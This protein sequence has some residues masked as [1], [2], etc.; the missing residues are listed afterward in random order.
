MAEGI[1]D[2]IYLSE[3]LSADATGVSEID[4][5]C[6][7]GDEDD[8]YDIPDDEEDEEQDFQDFYD[9]NEIELEGTELWLIG[10]RIFAGFKTIESFEN[11]GWDAAQRNIEVECQRFTLWAHGLGLHRVGHT[12]LDYQVR[13]AVVVKRRLA[14]VLAELADDIQEL[15]SIMRG[16]RVAYEDDRDKD[17]SSVASVRFND[18]ESVKPDNSEYS[19]IG[20]DSSGSFHEA[21]FRQKSVTEGIDTLY[22]LALIIRNPQNRPQRPLHRLYKHIAREVREQYIHEQEIKEIAVVSNIQRHHLQRPITVQNS[23]FEEITPG[24]IPE[25][26]LTPEMI[27]SYASDS[28]YLVRRIGIANARRKQQ[29]IYWRKHAAKIWG[30]RT[31]VERHSRDVKGKQPLREHSAPIASQMSEHIRSV[32]ARPDKSLAAAATRLDVTLLRPHDVKSVASSLSLASTMVTQQG[33]KLDWPS[34][35]TD[36]LDRN[37]KTFT[38][39]FCRMVLPESLLDAKQWRQHARYDLMPYI[40]TYEDS[41]DPDRLYASHREWC[42]HENGHTSVWHCYQHQQEFATQDEYIKH[43]NKW[44]P[45]AIPENILLEYTAQQAGPSKA[46]KRD[47]PLCPTVFQTVAE[48]QKHI[49]RHLER[50]AISC[51]PSRGMGGRAASFKQDFDQ[52]WD[53]FVPLRWPDGKGPETQKFIDD[54]A[55]QNS[56]L[57]TRVMSWLDAVDPAG[58]RIEQE[59]SSHNLQ[60]P[61]LYRGAGML[62]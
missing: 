17:R 61:A 13:D 2:P 28:N 41:S 57:Q 45:Q 6:G 25:H 4:D 16:E 7:A 37:T 27:E 21:D 31:V 35:P 38:C 49:R 36:L 48:M 15:H 51:F 18:G 54:N 3:Q 12:S 44:H 32:P 34:P 58:D 19:S 47:C 26:S 20:T 39:P 50:L 62:P 11:G 30:S 52:Y 55:P 42:N 24:T 46:P 29:F 1:P 14:E 5:L 22:S 33:H 59:I 43:I 8:S 10:A 9:E 60:L 23:Q 56:L 40:C 53:G